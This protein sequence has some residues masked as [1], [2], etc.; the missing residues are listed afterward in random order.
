MFQSN[1]ENYDFDQSYNLD[2]CD[3]PHTLDDNFDYIDFEEKH[4]TT[5]ESENSNDPADIAIQQLNLND[6]PESAR[7][8]INHIEVRMGEMLKF[9]DSKKG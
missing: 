8:R 5:N 3:Y 2:I 6:T 1:D 7:R 4:R 9:C